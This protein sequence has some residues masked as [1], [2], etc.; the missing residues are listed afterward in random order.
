MRL[1]KHYVPWNIVPLFFIETAV[2]FL[3]SSIFIKP[4][5][6]DRYYYSV[7]VFHKSLIFTSIIILTFYVSN[8]YDLKSFSKKRELFAV[9]ISCFAVSSIIIPV[10]GFV[11]PSLYLNR[12]EYFLSILVALPAV[13]TFR[14]FYSW[15]INVKPFRERLVI[16]GASNVAWRIVTE[17]RHGNRPGFDVLGVIAERQTSSQEDFLD[18]RILGD[19]EEFGQI[20]HEQR[21]DV[22]VVALSERRRA[23]PAKE[24]LACKLRGIRV[25]DW[26]T[27]Y[28]KL[29]GK[30]LIHN[31][32]P[33]WLI[34]ADGFA[35]N[36]LMRT[37]KRSLD[38]FFAAVGICMALPVMAILA[39][40]V[41]LDSPGPIL[42][43]QE[44]V[45]E[46]GK[47]FT[48]R[49]FRTM[50]A[51]AEKD[52]GPVWAQTTDPRVT[53]LGKIMRR[54]G[55]D[56]LPQLF[57]VLK[58]DMSFVGPRP[59][60]PHFVAELQRQIP[61]YTQRLAVQ[62]GI[63]GWAQVCY[64]YG[65]TLADAIEKLQYDLYYIKNM[66]IFLDLLT[67]L[68]T[69]HKV[70]FAKVAVQTPPVESANGSSFGS[71]VTWPPFA[72]DAE[73]SGHILAAQEIEPALSAVA[74][75]DAEA[76]VVN[77]HTRK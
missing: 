27:F 15:M 75:A 35:R 3:F 39:V 66:S 34:F 29:T 5:S 68:S 53:K 30:I 9:L 26:P 69:I 36:R 57:N 72:D 11:F 58:G 22:I 42:F 23:F 41:K 70:I 43:S 76:S 38:L 37:V 49:K 8:L 44:R 18:C 21:P 19:L 67:I 1:F 74:R 64:G 50:V 10:I 32:R 16:L 47:I 17:L 65:A 25:E 46:G 7:G 54:T 73:V 12:K 48:L 52:T 62:P 13:F 33:S 56:E 60:R 45:G 63:T 4:N 61:Y 14:L 51:D 59:E 55:M 40:L 77:T 20:I 71:E 2:L 28:E 6:F 24:I 31:L